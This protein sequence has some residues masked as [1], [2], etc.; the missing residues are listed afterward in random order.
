MTKNKELDAV[1][2]RDIRPPVQDD[3]VFL[4]VYGTL[5]EG[6]SRHA[7][8]SQPNVRFLDTIILPNYTL[9]DLGPF[10]TIIRSQNNIIGVVCELYQLPMSVL[11]QIDTLEDCPDIFTRELAPDTNNIFV[12]TMR[13]HEAYAYKTKPIIWIQSGD[14]VT[15]IN[16]PKQDEPSLEDAEEN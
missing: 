9:L 10:P 4:L 8:L 11:L 6:M 12:Y 16:P 15:Y 7:I 1:P 13:M 3:I 2:I 14:Y 5:R